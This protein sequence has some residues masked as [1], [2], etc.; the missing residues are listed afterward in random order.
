MT[1]R[2][3]LTGIV[4]AIGASVAAVV[5]I[6]AA[7][8]SLAPALDGRKAQVWRPVGRLDD[9]PL[10]DVRKAVVEAP[11]VYWAQ[12]LPAVAVFVWRPAA[13]E[14]VVFSRSCT[15]LGCPVTWDPGSEWFFCPCHGGIFAKDGTPK[16]GPPPRPLY[17]YAARVQ[18]GIVEIDLNSLPPSAASTV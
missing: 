4:A 13:G 11:R 12:A 10:G 14:V 16:A 3:W 6:P 5:G 15:D 9:F 8:F 17:R 1:R 18:G 7:L 2:G